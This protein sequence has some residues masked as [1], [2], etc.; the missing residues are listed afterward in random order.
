VP[1]RIARAR[2]PPAHRERHGPV[3]DV[4]ISGRTVRLSNLD[5]VLWPATGFTKAQLVDYYVRV[6]PVLLP[7][8][9]RRPITLARFPDGVDVDGWYQSE[10]WQ[11][12]DWMAT[13]KVVLPHGTAAGRDYCV[14]DDAP[15]LAWAANQAAIELHPLLATVDDL[16]A[17]LAVVF[18]LD[19]G[20]PATLGDCAA[21]ACRL[22]ETLAALDLAS[23]PKT[24]GAKGMQVYV[25]LHTPHTYADTKAF[26]RAIASILAER[27]E[28]L[29]VDTMAKA[30]RAGKVFVDWSQND[31]NKSTIAPYSLRSTTTPA[32]SAPL[33][34]DEIEAAANTRDPAMLVIG[35]DEVFA[36]LERDG[37]LFEPVLTQH[38]R[39][40]TSR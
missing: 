31:R 9:Q 32:V 19:P 23:Y 36:R 24:S 7:H 2:R 11:H 12:P 17:P 18:D 15:A 27:H 25:P 21:V 38:Q 20:P 34:W 26:A 16:D 13:A 29:V 10:C 8:V 1:Q 4:E 28:A 6:A 39:L 14:F 40:P 37:D 35:V 5:K 22:R 3:V 33:R 30:K